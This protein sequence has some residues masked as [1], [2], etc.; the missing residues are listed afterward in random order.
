MRYMCQGASPDEECLRQRIDPQE[1]KNNKKRCVLIFKDMPSMRKLFLLPD[2]FYLIA[3][4]MIIHKEEDEEHVDDVLEQAMADEQELQDM[5]REVSSAA[6]MSE[7]M[8]INSI[9]PVRLSFDFNLNKSLYKVS[10]K[11]SPQI[12][13]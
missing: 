2:E 3:E 5:R 9:I 1:N 7:M 13:H 12:C 11:T 4:N 8:M 10:Q 6:L